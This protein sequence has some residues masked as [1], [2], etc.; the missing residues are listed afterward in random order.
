M[1]IFIILGTSQVSTANSALFIL[2]GLQ[3]FLPGA[4]HTQIEREL[5]A[6]LREELSTYQILSDEEMNEA[7]Q[8]EAA[9]APLKKCYF[10]PRGL[11]RNGDDCKFRHDYN[12]DLEE[13]KRL[14]KERKREA[15]KHQQ[16]QVCSDSSTTQSSSTHSNT[17]QATQTFPVQIC[18]MF[19]NNPSNPSEGF[20]YVYYI[21]NQ[22]YNAY[23]GYHPLLGYTMIPFFGVGTPSFQGASLVD[24]NAPSLQQ[25]NTNTNRRPARTH[26]KRLYIKKW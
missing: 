14:K 19:F 5:N 24:E 1:L 23:L 4:I 17:A 6:D 21:Y 16:L 3:G 11:C 13:E 8:L 20:Y 25:R 12:V 7:I 2:T 9:Y 18:Q 10:H 15:R 22:N 26:P